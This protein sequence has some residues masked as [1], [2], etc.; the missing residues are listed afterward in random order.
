M[1]T[2]HIELRVDLGTSAG[3]QVVTGVVEVVRQAGRWAVDVREAR[4]PVEAT[5]DRSRLQEGE[6]GG[7]IAAE[8]ASGDLRVTARAAQGASAAAGEPAEVWV[9]ADATAAGRLAADAAVG[10]GASHVL[11]VAEVPADRTSPGSTEAD[12]GSNAVAVAVRARLDESGRVVVAGPP[13]P[14][15]PA[16]GGEFGRWVAWAATV[17]KPC[18]A[19]ARTAA[20]GYRLLEAARA[21]GVR[22]PDDLH[23]VAAD[24]DDVLAPLARPSLARV[25]RDWQEV[26]RRAAT[27]LARLLAG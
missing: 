7:T 21:G 14:C 26:G 23:V 16:G 2:S 19:V 15:G 4:R 10:T 13:G 6:P 18:A 22:V 3:R 25:D 20:D 9:R 12:L 27:E 5:G 17:P 11:L 24:G 1:R 8:L